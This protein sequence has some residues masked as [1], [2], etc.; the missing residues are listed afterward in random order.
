L[1]HKKATVPVGEHK[2]APRESFKPLPSAGISRDRIQ[3]QIARSLSI[4]V[5]STNATT[6]RQIWPSF[7]LAIAVQVADEATH[8]QD[9][10]TGF[11]QPMAVVCG[12]GNKRRLHKGDDL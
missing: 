2:A 11:P 10:G 7:E 6:T 5:A 4:F 9:A 8:L 3:C 12:A 1:W